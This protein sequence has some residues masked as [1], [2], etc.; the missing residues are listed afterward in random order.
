MAVGASVSSQR[1]WFLR[2]SLVGMW[3][4]TSRLALGVLVPWVTSW[5][6]PSGR[7]QQTITGLGDMEITG[8]VVLVRDRSFSPQHLLWGS[9]GL[10]FP[11]GPRLEDDQGYPYSDDDQPGSGSW[12]PI[13]GVAYGWYGGLTSVFASTLFKYPTGSARG[14]RRGANLSFSALVQIQPWSWGAISLGMI[15]SWSRPDLLPNG[16]EMAN[17]GGTHLNAAV[18]LSASPRTDILLRLGVEVP[19]TQDLLNGQQENGTQ[20]VFSMAYDIH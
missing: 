15:G 6:T 9:G 18:A 3:A 14:F 2:S 12:D 7:S 13:G 10:K 4:P 19:V 17:S 20:I 1:G 16:R 5:M 8:R 11:T